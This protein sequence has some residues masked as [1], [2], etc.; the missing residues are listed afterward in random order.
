MKQLQMKNH[1]QFLIVIPKTKNRL[2]F[3]HKRRFLL[4][5][6]ELVIL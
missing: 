3:L 4:L 2:K 6:K 5:E 1:E